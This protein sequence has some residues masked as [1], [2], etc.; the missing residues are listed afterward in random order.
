MK[1]MKMQLMK[2]PVQ[3]LHPV[4]L[5]FFQVKQNIMLQAK[6]QPQ[7]TSQFNSQQDVPVD[8]VVIASSA[9]SET[10]AQLPSMLQSTSVLVK[11]AATGRSVK[12]GSDQS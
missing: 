7:A 2:S 12:T 11:T 6:P 5:L 3:R 1:T 10:P 4:F 8:T 9:S